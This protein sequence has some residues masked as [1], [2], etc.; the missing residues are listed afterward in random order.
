M[1]VR[2]I[3]ASELLTEGGEVLDEDEE[4]AESGGWK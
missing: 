4:A 1:V 2:P 3:W